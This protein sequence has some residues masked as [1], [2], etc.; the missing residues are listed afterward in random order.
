MPLKFRSRMSLNMLSSE[1]R[2]MERGPVGG[3][4]SFGTCCTS[5]E[6]I[7]RGNLAASVAKGREKGEG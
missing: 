5:S 6:N 7:C 2:E 1:V 3:G 4:L